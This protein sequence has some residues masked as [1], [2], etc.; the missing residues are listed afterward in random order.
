[1]RE[2]DTTIVLCAGSLNTMNPQIGTNASNAMVPVNGKPVIG[3]I[4][5]DLLR[6]KMPATTVVIRQ[7]NERLRLFL[8]RA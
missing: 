8:S 5:D 4:L 6:K 7:D 3:G 1:M 2:P